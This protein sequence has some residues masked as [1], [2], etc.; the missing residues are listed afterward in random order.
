[1][2]R[3]SQNEKILKYIKDFGSIT[4]LQ[5]FNDL[6]VTRLSGRIY[7]LQTEGYRFEKRFETGKNRY[8]ENVSYVRY[9]LKEPQKEVEK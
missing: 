8:N 4:S 3:M 6:G 9:F 1:M 7:D 5:A 2:A